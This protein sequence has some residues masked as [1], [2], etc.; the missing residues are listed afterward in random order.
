MNRKFLATVL[1]VASVVGLGVWIVAFGKGWLDE[2]KASRVTTDE[3][4]SK[5]RTEKFGA[6]ARPQP[7]FVRNSMTCWYRA[8]DST[9]GRAS[10]AT[11]TVD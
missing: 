8:M 2:W 10:S 3:E 7:M 4:L 6:A 11:A 5:L 1:A 9:N